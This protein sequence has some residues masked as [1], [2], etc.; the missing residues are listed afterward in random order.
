MRRWTTVHFPFDQMISIA[1]VLVI[2]LI[3]TSS[4]L[5]G[6]GT[7]TKDRA[8]QVRLEADQRDWLQRLED[9]ASGLGLRGY[10]RSRMIRDAVA[11]YLAPLIELLNREGKLGRSSDDRLATDDSSGKEFGESMRIRLDH[12]LVGQ[13]DR[14]E[15]YARGLGYR[16]VTR[17]SLI[18]DAIKAYVTGF[19][20]ELSADLLGRAQ[21]DSVAE[22]N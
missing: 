6:S 2:A 5:G 16:H 9:H 22:S 15:A 1:G 8:V 21:S 10:T 13:L 3:A 18:R 4:R 14:V 17:S 19:D 12:D 11:A 20:R 7:A